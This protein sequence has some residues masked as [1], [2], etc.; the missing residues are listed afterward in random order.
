MILMQSGMFGELQVLHLFSFGPDGQGGYSANHE[1]SRVC[2]TIGKEGLRDFIVLPMDP[3]IVLT[4]CDEEFGNYGICIPDALTTR[5][6]QRQEI[7]LYDLEVTL[8][9]KKSGSKGLRQSLVIGIQVK[10]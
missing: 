1:A 2:E 5:S 6:L 7:I 9:E 10:F 3:P 4:F 8:G